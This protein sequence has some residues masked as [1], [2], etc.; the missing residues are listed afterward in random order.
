[1]YSDGH[2]GWNRI[3]QHTDG[4]ETI[5]RVGDTVY[6]DLSIP[7]QKVYLKPE[8]RANP[9]AAEA[10]QESDLIVFA[11]GNLYTSTVPNLL[12]KGIPEALRQTGLPWFTFST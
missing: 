11:P 12:V 4:T 6:C 7:I 9:Q 8:A 3:F 5:R 2:R 1:M 10:I